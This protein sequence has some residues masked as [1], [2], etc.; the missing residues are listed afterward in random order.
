MALDP[1]AEL[2]PYPVERLPAG[3]RSGFVP[4][5]NGLRIH[6]L[7]A[8]FD[9][10]DRP[11]ILL[12]HGFPE[13]AYSWRKVMLPLAAAGYHVIAPDQRGYG[14]T[15]GWDADYDG[16]LSQFQLLNLVRDAI[17]LAFAFGYHSLAVVGHDFG[18]PVAAWCALSRPDVFDRVALMSAP[19]AGP[20]VL[21]FDTLSHPPDTTRPR[22]DLDTEFGKLSPPRK[23][24]QQYYQSREANANLWQAPQGVH[25][26]LRAYYHYKSADWRGNRPFTLSGRGA[27]EMAQMPT[28]YIMNQADGMAETVAPH[29]PSPASIAANGWLPEEA[30]KVYAEEFSRTGFQG[31]LNWYRASAGPAAELFAGCRI[32]QPSIFISGESDW[33]SYQN[34]GALERMREQVCSDLRGIHMVDGAGHWLQQE[35]PGITGRLLLEF[36]ES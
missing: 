17:G 31:G 11:G 13:L 25:D 2:A 19:F 9:A 7:E 8:G 4:D 24:Y 12:L 16:D 15:S 22:P 32:D 18:S 20:P 6:V 34:P 14:R 26:F 29:M 3:I 30:L 1:I 27:A 21:P 10:G 36:L 35:Q 23:H 5:V 28:Y 33:G